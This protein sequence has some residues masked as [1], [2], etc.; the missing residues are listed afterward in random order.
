MKRKH[1]N[2]NIISALL[3]LWAII[4]MAL[5]MSV[6]AQT[7]GGFPNGQLGGSAPQ[8]TE[9]SHLK[10]LQDARAKLTDRQRKLKSHIEQLTQQAMLENA[11][12]QIDTTTQGKHLQI[13]LLTCGPGQ[14]IYEYYGHSAIR[15]L[16]T[17]STA[18]DLVFNYG[19]FDFESSNFVLRFALGETDYLCV[20]QET[21][22]FLEHFRRKGIYVDEQIL[23][24]TQTEAQRIFD[25]LVENVK[26]ENCVYRYNFFFDNC[27]TRVRNIIENNLSY[28]LQYPSRPT[29]RSL[30]DAVHFYSHSHQWSTFG[31]DLLLGSQADLP[32]SGRDLQ[33]APLILAQDFDNCVILDNIYQP[34]FFVTEKHRLIDPSPVV[35]S[36]FPLSP[37]A[38]TVLLAL[39]VIGVTIFEF[40][41]KRIFW[42]LD[43]LL[44]AIQG[45]SGAIPTFLFFFSTHPT[46]D[47]NWLIWIL[48]PLPLVGIYWQIKGA[49][50]Q[51][52]YA[53]H[54][55][56]APVIA[57]FLIATR[58]IPQYISSTLMTL[59]LILLIRSM[60]SLIMYY[61]V[62]KTKAKRK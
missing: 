6:G 35:V 29:E 57:A 44:L 61:Y 40:R 36:E 25:A 12:S 23:N 10:Q 28:K 9:E 19:I 42:P 43:T 46:V 13:S 7:T 11:K 62:R 26:P 32:A 8:Q 53:Y 39:I 5:P 37:M 33:F 45:I 1:T 14:E 4:F 58:F 50:K 34:H 15:V 31:Q 54:I 17:D 52:Y 60:T 56:A 16:R 55:V 30:R 51:K 48:N 38:T 20:A 27:A 59:A 24:V 22:N 2:K 18:L 49:L 21:E 3:Y 47:S 41:K